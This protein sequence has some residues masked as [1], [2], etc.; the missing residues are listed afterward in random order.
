VISTFRRR[1]V[2]QDG[3]AG[4]SLTEIVVATAVSLLVLTMVGSLFIQTATLTDNAT[5]N[6]NSTT[7]ASTAAAE[8][9]KVVRLA[10]PVQMTVSGKPAIVAAVASATSTK[11]SVYSY[12]DT[13]AAVPVPTLVT[14]DGSGTLLTET[15]CPGTAS[16]TVWSFTCAKPAVRSLG[17]SIVAPATGQN[18]LFN[19][20]AT[21][22][23]TIPLVGG[24]LPAANLNSVASV[25]VSINIQAVGSKTDPVYLTS[26]VGM[27]NVGLTQKANS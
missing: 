16:G 26:N 2:A 19:Y 13:S 10:T 3:E 12:A 25:L 15:R 11:L 20:L 5:Q 22:G 7:V 24:V 18:Q 8:I 14:F 17:G 27:P 21:D 4:L 9:S 23:T 1:L 6:R